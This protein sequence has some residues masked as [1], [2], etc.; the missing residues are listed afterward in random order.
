MLQPTAQTP[1]IIPAQ[2]QVRG[3]SILLPTQPL[4]SQSQQTRDVEWVADGPN[5]LAL[6]PTAS[7]MWVGRVMGVLFVLM[8]L[9]TV[10]FVWQ[11][12]IPVIVRGAWWAGAFILLTLPFLVLAGLAVRSL[13]FGPGPRR[14][15][16]DRGANRLVVDRRYGLAGSYRT[17]V[18]YPLAEVVAVQLLY[19][20]RHSYT[21]TSDQ[22]F[23]GTSGEFFTYEMNL[24]LDDAGRPRL[25]LCTHARSEEHTSELQS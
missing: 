22:P 4:S 18:T 25:H 6:V 15:R 21:H 16:F 7:S 3:R 17:E 10:G 19:T 5:S 8:L 20:G 24:I 14:Y 2:L 1:T 11:L 13:F 12:F 9:G 23:Q